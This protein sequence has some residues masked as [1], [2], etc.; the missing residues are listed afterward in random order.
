MSRRLP[1][2]ALLGLLPALLVAGACSGKQRA[3]RGAADSSTIEVVDAAGVRHTLPGPVRRVV[4]LVPSAT[5]TLAALGAEDV[6]VGRTDFDTTSWA[7]HIPS[8][9]GGLHP[10]IEA[11]VA[12]H[13]D[14]VVSFAGTQDRDTP[15]RLAGFGIPDLAIR[16]DRIAD[17]KKE[18]DILGR[19]TGHVQ[20]ADSLVRS[21]DRGLAGIRSSVAG[22]P[23]P[24]VAYLLGGTPP[25]VAGSG[26][27]IDELVTIAGGHN[28]FHDLGSLYAAVSPEEIAARD[29][30]VV[31]VPRSATFDR[32]LAPHA[33]VAVVSGALELPGPDVV[34][35]ARDLARLIHGESHQ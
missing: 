23:K 18:I 12:L 25:W 9:G 17:V 34:S 15:A 14:V 21:I 29:I 2:R 33:R 19:V 26:T 27:Y 5:L 24:R 16:P 22:L 3:T 6:L 7:A 1:P 8:V 4:S 10:S 30:Q 32:R 28:V 20:R 35:A 13:P 11:I 31:L